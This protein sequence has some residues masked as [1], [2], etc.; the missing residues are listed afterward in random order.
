MNSPGNETQVRMIAEQVAEAA[1]TNVLMN[2]PELRKADI[3]APLNWASV[4]IS[5]LFTA[6]MAAL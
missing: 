4:I 5:G 3:P 1:V 2:H 6:G